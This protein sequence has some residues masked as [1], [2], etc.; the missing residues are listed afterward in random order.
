MGRCRGRDQRPEAEESA[1][2]EGGVTETAK[3]DIAIVIAGLMI[4]LWF[5]L[6]LAMRFIPPDPIPEELRIGAMRRPFSLPHK[7]RNS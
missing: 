3:T 5:L 4:V 6:Y 1:D 7:H 2:E